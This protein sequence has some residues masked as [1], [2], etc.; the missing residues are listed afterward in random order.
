MR[1]ALYD[2]H[3][4]PALIAQD[5]LPERAASRML[6][7]SRDG[8]S[9]HQ[10]VAELPSLLQGGDLVVLNTTRVIPARLHGRKASGGALEVLLM[11][12][13]APATA[14]AA[15]AA[16]ADG[17]EGKDVDEAAG[18]RWRVMIRGKVKD[19]T[20]ILLD[21]ARARVLACHA[22][23]TRS[24]GFPPGIEV[25]ALAQAIG[26]VPL[27]PYIA[28]SDAASDRERYQT[29]F[30]RHPGSVAAPTAGLHLDQAA[31]GRLRQRGVAIAEVEL[32]IGPGTFK[33]VDTERIEDFSIHQEHCRCPI[34]T[35]A[36]IKQCRARGG[37]VIAVGTTVLRTLET[38]ARQAHGIDAFEG[39]TG[40]FLRPP[41]RLRV[42]DGLLTN[43]H[44]PRSSLLMAVSCLCGRRQ[45]LDWYQCAIDAGYRF[46]SYGDCML[47]LPRR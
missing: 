8:A 30:A 7:C 16:A 4:P 26:H 47:L 36:A 44:M 18:E 46:L 15:A 33:P 43:F 10:G 17:A 29:V 38:A 2:Y 5:P 9:V 28:R 21:G 45:L 37:K 6:V 11:H 13:E 1:T 34:E 23:G 22:D 31:L 19:G 40:L 27:P 20:E 39:W 25:L 12:A 14:T 41:A 42:V 35:V 24:I 3:L 32:A